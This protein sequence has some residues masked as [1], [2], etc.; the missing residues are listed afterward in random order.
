[1][2]DL[3]ELNEAQKEAVLHGEGPARVLAG[4]GSGKTHVIVKRLELL[5]REKK[6]PP[7]FILV[8]TFTRAAAQQ[9]QSR[10][11]RQMGETFYPVRFSTFHSF[12]Y[13]LI[14]SDRI[15]SAGGTDHTLQILSDSEKQS[16]LQ[17]LQFEYKQHF[18][19]K[20][21]PTTEQISQF[22]AQ[23]KNGCARKPEAFKKWQMYSWFL[24][25]Y[26][27]QLLSLHRLDLED[28]AKRCAE[29]LQEPA[30]RKRWQQRFSYVLVDEF[31]DIN[32]MQYRVL[33]L[34]MKKPANLFVVG[35]DDQSIYG[36][37]GSDPGLLRQ[38]VTDYPESARI[39]LSYNYRSTKR[40]LDTAGLCISQNQNRIEKKIQAAGKEDSLEESVFIKEALDSESQYREI[41][42]LIRKLISTGYKETDLALIGRTNRELEEAA[43]YFLQEKIPCKRHGKQKGVFEHFLWKDLEACLRIASGEER[44][45]DF[46]QMQQPFLRVIPRVLF[47]E[48]LRNLSALETMLFRQKEMTLRE[49]RLEKAR[50]KELQYEKVRQFQR[51]CAKLQ[52]MPPGLAINYIRKGMGYETYLQSR[53]QASSEER[54][55]LLKQ[56]DFYQQYAASF[57]DQKALLENIQIRRE[58]GNDKQPQEKDGVWLLTMHGSKGLEF[59]VVIL[60]DLNEGVI[61][62]RNVTSAEEMEEERRMLYVAMTRAKEKLY[63]FYLGGDKGRKKLPSRFLFPILKSRNIF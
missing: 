2:P 30:C 45:G 47:A 56:L 9:M 32:P 55:Q 25:E 5:V 44:E 21:V 6:I 39:L 27:R 31:Q 63:L 14:Q 42:E 3:W 23:Q 38:F 17:Q 53:Y 7:E 41:A 34:L 11:L 62:G 60:P 33:R 43:L 52:K 29:L 57:T 48:S 54:K 8:L 61:P 49:G 26:D 24:K 50:E 40:I 12:F 51:D 58:E 1:M 46:L 10:F 20:D 28:L 19:E 35:D 15:H 18:R 13:Y 37:R 59:P 36:F 16:L 22:I 4:P